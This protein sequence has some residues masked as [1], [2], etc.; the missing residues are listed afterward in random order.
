MACAVSLGALAV[1]QANADDLKDKQKHVQGQIHSATKDLDESSARL[2]RATAALERARAEL[3]TPETSW[4]PR[5]PSGTP[6][7]CATSR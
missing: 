3:Q 5:V 4:A 2:R 7:T 1:P 6:R